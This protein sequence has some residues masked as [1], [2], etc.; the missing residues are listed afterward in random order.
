[1][2]R[3]PGKCVNVQS[4]STGQAARKA[5]EGDPGE[6]PRRANT[7]DIDG[8][9]PGEHPPPPPSPPPR[10]RRHTVAR[11]QELEG[12]EEESMGGQDSM[13]AEKESSAGT[14]FPTKHAQTAV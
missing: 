13:L 3:L 2:P 11:L 12:S 7:Q 14:Q 6:A 5:A 1:M 8:P 9:A 4:V 10:A